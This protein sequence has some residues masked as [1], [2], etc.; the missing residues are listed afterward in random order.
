MTETTKRPRGRPRILQPRAEWH[1]RIALDVKIA[2]LDHID[3]CNR[4]YRRTGQ[5]ALSQQEFTELAF[6]AFLQNARTE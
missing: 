4:V 1:C 5:P 3:E 6:K 2:A